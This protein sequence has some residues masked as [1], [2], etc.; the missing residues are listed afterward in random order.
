M[1]WE[2]TPTVRGKACVHR[3][4]DNAHVLFALLDVTP[5]PLSREK[6]DL[7]ECVVQC[8]QVFI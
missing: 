2:G 6:E 1:R 8:M 5:L 4:G 7:S 3:L